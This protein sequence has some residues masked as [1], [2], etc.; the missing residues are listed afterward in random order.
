MCGHSDDEWYVEDPETG[1]R[2]LD[3]NRFIARRRQCMGC[4]KKA[5]A[6][7]ALSENLGAQDDKHAV[8]SSSHFD[9]VPAELMEEWEKLPPRGTIG[10]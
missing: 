5:M 1:E 6:R 2:H 10:M 7:D 4:Y 9:L 8:L 3:P